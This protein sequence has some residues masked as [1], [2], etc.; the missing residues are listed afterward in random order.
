VSIDTYLLFLL[1]TPSPRDAEIP[2]FLLAGHETTSTSVTWILYALSINPIVQDKLRAE[3]VSC[4]LGDRPDM[5][6]L[7]GLVYL[8]FVIRETLRV[9]PPAVAVLRVADKDEV[10]PTECTWEDKHGVRRTGIPSVICY[11]SGFR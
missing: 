10:I 4:G 5:E 2:T 8:E 6:A 11:F 1:V 3:L 9:Y 7:N